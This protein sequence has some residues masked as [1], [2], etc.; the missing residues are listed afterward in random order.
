MLKFK[1]LILK[2]RKHC[3][4]KLVNIVIFEYRKNDLTEKWLGYSIS[5]RT[6]EQKNVIVIY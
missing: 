2:R 6:K 4:S 5:Q 1:L 3:D